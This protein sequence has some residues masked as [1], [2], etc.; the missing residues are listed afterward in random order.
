MIG[1]ESTSATTPLLRRLDRQPR[2]VTVQVTLVGHPERCQ[3]VIV[4]GEGYPAHFS[5]LALRVHDVI[6]LHLRDHDAWGVPE[7]S[8][9]QGA[10]IVSEYLDL[11]R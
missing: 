1:V 2:L 5:S 4:D 8:I 9:Q 3:A 6:G 11:I 10:Q 7:H